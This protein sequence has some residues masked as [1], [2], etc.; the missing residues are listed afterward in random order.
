MSPF[1]FET[2]PYVIQPGDTYWLLAQRFRTPVHDIVAAN[3]NVDPY[4]LFVGQVICIPCVRHSMPFSS[5]R[6]SPYQNVHNCISKAEVDLKSLMRTLWEQHVAWTRM[7]IISIAANLPDQELVTKRLLRNA[8][9]MANALKPFYGEENAAT[10]ERLIR[11]H[12]VIADQLVKAAKAGDSKAAANAEKRWYKNA[13][14]IASFLNSINPY[15]S[16]EDIR[17][18]FYEHLALTKAEAVYRLNNNFALDIATFDKIEQQALEMAD[19]FTDGIVKQFPN[20]FT[21]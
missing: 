2:F 18:M 13:D 17:K 3:P 20:L 14:E 11:D 19:A 8:T 5:P 6:P 21:N 4:Y 15:W 10:F 1:S 16:E 7:V 12:L 9:D